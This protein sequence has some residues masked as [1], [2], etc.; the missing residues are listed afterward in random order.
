V[1][2]FADTMPEFVGGKD[3]LL[4]FLRKNIKYPKLLVAIKEQYIANLLLKKTGVF[5]TLKS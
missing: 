3:S 1:F 4:S 2:K 5:Q